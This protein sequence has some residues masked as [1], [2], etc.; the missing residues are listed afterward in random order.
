MRFIELLF[1]IVSICYYFFHINLFTI[2][3]SSNKNPSSFV[4]NIVI[5]VRNPEICCQAKFEALKDQ[6]ER[7]GGREK[8]LSQEFNGLKIQSCTI[9]SFYVYTPSY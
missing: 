9:Q 5:G 3:R 1:E 7:E 6:R 8:C 2:V 4:I